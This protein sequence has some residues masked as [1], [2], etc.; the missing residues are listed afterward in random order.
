MPDGMIFCTGFGEYLVM[1]SVLKR[2]AAVSAALLSMVVAAQAQVSV[3]T[4]YYNITG[5]TGMELFWDMNRK[6]PRHGFLTKAIAQTQFKTDLKGD[7]VYSNGVCRTKNARYSLQI[8]YVYPNPTTKLDAGLAKRWRAFQ[9]SN[10]RHEQEHG[11]L[12]RKFADD[13]NRTLRNFKM[14]D[15]QSCRKAD[16]ALTKQLDSIIV[17]YNK[18]Q[19]DFDKREH[20]D[21]GPVEKS[22][23]ALVGK[24]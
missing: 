11:R 18:S 16:R 12:G 7:I 5:K 3:S 10:V 19:V 6:G 4:K 2:A 23:L 1:F 9:A 13:M 15:K 20:R 17:S 24:R 22:I 14:A 21:G 8:T